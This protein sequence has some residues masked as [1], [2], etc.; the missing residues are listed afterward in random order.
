MA[1]KEKYNVPITVKF[2]ETLVKAMARRIEHK[3]KKFPRYTEADFIR[4]A[5]VNHLKNKGYLD[6]NKDYL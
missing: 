6:K 1:T 5:V 2:P 4:T 3:Q